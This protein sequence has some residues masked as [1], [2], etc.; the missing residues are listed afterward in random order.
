MFV[1]VQN[2][3]F[4]SL[5]STLQ[6]R[7]VECGAHFAAAAAGRISGGA[8]RAADGAVGFLCVRSIH[9]CGLCANEPSI[10]SRAYTAGADF[11]LFCRG[12]SSVLSNARM[13]GA[14]ARASIGVGL[15]AMVG[16]GGHSCELGL[17]PSAL[18]GGGAMGMEFW[19]HDARIYGRVGLVDGGA[20]LYCKTIN[21]SKMVDLDRQRTGLGYGSRFA[22]HH[23]AVGAQSPQEHTPASA[24]DEADAIHA[25]NSGALR[26]QFLHRPSD[27][28]TAKPV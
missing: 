20:D 3:C 28:P 13:V 21:L 19:P 10:R 9:R 6:A 15:A 18:A 5:A 2:G 24:L 16:L 1:Y 27:T 8:V 12:I 17:A 14:V 22:G 23:R 25:G 11:T 7:P 26:G 4:P